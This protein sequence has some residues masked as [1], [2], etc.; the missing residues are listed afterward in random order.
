MFGKAKKKPRQGHTA[1]GRAGAKV[2]GPGS[3]KKR[4]LRA[5]ALGGAGKGGR[6]KRP[7][8][9]DDGKRW[10]GI[11]VRIPIDDFKAPQGVGLGTG[12]KGRGRRISGR[13]GNFFG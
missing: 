13:G 8:T 4:G 3:G 7:G 10:R 1:W 9:Q 5:A 12:G 11:V 2:A 6:K